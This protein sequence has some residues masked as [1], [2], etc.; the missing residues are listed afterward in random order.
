MN[1]DAVFARPYRRARRVRTQPRRH[2]DRQDQAP[3]VETRQR[4]PGQHRPQP[5]YVDPAVVQAAVHR[6][7][8]TTMFGQQ[9]QVHRG[10]HRTVRTQHRVRQF[11]QLVAP[12]GQTLIE[13]TPEA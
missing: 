9:R 6:S 5:I 3:A 7:V 2:I 1:C 10:L 8:P 11:E 4:K 13:L 12:S